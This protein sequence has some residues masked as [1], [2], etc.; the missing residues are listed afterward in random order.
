[1]LLFLPKTK[2]IPVIAADYQTS[3]GYC[4]RGGDRAARFVFP[5]LLA[6]CQIDGVE[7]SVVRAHENPL[8][9]DNRRAVY[10]SAGGELPEQFAFGPVDSVQAFVA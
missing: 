2:K 9:Y 6:A 8:A 7:A 4:G 5:G 10:A 1:M 3:G